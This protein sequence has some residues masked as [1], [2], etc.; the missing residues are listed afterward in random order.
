MKPE[1]EGKTLFIGT[2]IVMVGGIIGG[3]ITAY[4][5]GKEYGKRDLMKSLKEKN[6]LR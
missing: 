3:F 5:S 6:R 1:P 4:E 2:A